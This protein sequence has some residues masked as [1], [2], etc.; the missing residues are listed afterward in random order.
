MAL[1]DL[2]PTSS[3]GDLDVTIKEEDGSEQHF[4]QPFTSL[5]IL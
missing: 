5:A 2:N 4:I 3:G 1:T